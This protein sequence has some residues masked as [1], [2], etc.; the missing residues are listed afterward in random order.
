[1]H[2]CTGTE[3]LYRPYG[4]QGEQGYSSTLSSLRH[5]KGVRGQRHAP[6]ALYPR[7][8]PGTHCTGGW[9][10]PRT[11]LERCGKPHLH[12]DSIPGPSS[13][14]PVAIPTTPPG[15]HTRWNRVVN[16]SFRPLNPQLQT[17]DTRLLQNRVGPG[18]VR[19]FWKRARKPDPAENGG[20]FDN[21]FI[22]AKKV[23]FLF[24]KKNYRLRVLSFPTSSHLMQS[25]PCV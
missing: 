1:M 12:R 3:A 20:S 17:F 10:G 8:R 13:L 15:P 24:E 25:N 11:G 9:V 19:A 22:W 18:P 21:S 4:L 6:A 2:P 7:E 5:Q 16:V 14:Q 23:F